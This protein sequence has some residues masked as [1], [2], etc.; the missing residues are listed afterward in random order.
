MKVIPRP[1]HLAPLEVPDEIAAGIRNFL[2]SLQ[3]KNQVKL[4]HAPHANPFEYGLLG[5]GRLT[6]N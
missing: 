3:S 1:G 6:L 4:G 2:L 5:L